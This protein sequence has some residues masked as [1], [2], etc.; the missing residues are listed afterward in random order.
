M[1]C[2]TSDLPADDE[3]KRNEEKDAMLHLASSMTLINT[4]YTVDDE[5]AITQL[6]THDREVIQELP[7]LPSGRASNVK[8][9]GKAKRRRSIR[10]LTAALNQEEDAGSA[11]GQISQED[12]AKAPN[13]HISPTRDVENLMNNLETD[14]AVHQCK[15]QTQ[16]VENPIDNLETY[17]AAQSNLD[18]C[19][20]TGEAGLCS[21]NVDI[22]IEENE[23]Y[24]STHFSHSQETF[25]SSPNNGLVDNNSQPFYANLAASSALDKAS[26]NNQPEENAT[27]RRPKRRRSGVTLSA[28]QK[29]EV[30]C[31]KRCQKSNEE[32]V[33]ELYL[34]RGESKALKQSN[35]ET[36]FE[37]VHFGKRG[38]PVYAGSRKCKRSL[39]FLEH[40]W[41]PRKRKKHQ[42]DKIS[43]VK[44]KKKSLKDPNID[45]KLEALL[46]D[47]TLSPSQPFTP[48]W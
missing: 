39:T 33:K 30:K 43:Q 3:V 9:V 22:E 31:K 13:L 32:S 10:L 6:N 42:K 4:C 5:S 15:N 8:P 19:N 21:E 16:N 18:V 48:L 29:R 34:K 7:V 46:A 36:I 40:P 28:V 38:S 17:T 24:F 1:T 2:N 14:A 25:T 41:L 35:L 47:L 20:E 12:E 27:S 45:K 26:S 37:E 44:R 23:I 11:S